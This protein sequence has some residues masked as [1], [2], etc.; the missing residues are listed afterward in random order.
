MAMPY[1]SYFQHNHGPLFEQNSLQLCAH[2][3]SMLPFLQQSLLQG[4]VLSRCGSKSCLLI[5]VCCFTCNTSQTITRW[6]FSLQIQDKVFHFPT[7]RTPPILSS[8]HLWKYKGLL[9]SKVKPGSPQ[10]R[11]NPHASAELWEMLK[12]IRKP[13]DQLYMKFRR[14]NL[15]SMRRSRESAFWGFESRFLHLKR[16]VSLM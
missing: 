4:R 12:E 16:N 1:L 5:S 10:T 3:M 13:I 9:M 7:E 8:I 15:A 6:S 14:P 2:T 11:K